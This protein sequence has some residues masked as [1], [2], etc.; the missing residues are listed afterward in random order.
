ME[1][2]P[3]NFCVFVYGSGHFSRRAEC[4]DLDRGGQSKIAD[5]SRLRSD[6]RVFTGSNPYGD[7]F[8]RGADILLDLFAIP[9]LKLT[10][11]V[12]AE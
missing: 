6:N 12:V 9:Q 10:P 1:M 4:P 7:L 11:L 8:S 2:V 5:Q 3:R